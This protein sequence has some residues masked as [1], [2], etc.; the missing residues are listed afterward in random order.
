MSSPASG[1][2]HPG[3]APADGSAV[4]LVNLGT[5]ASPTTAATRRY[6]AEFL[7]D[8]RVIELPRLVWL[9]LLYG[10]ILPLRAARSAKAYRQ[11][12]LPDGSPLRVHSE[13]LAAELERT[14]RQQGIDLPVRLAMRY[15]SPSVAATLRALRAEGL[16]R[17][18]VLPLYPQY[19]ATTTASVFDAVG[20]ELRGWRRIPELRTIAD[21]HR[22]PAWLDAVA[23]SVRGH[24]RTHPRG[25]RLL[26]SFHGIPQRYVDAG[27]PYYEQCVVSAR[28]IATRLGL[29]DDAW[30]LCF[31][32]RVGREAWLQPYTEATI[33]ACAARGQ[34][35]LDVVCPGFAVDCLETLEEI[36]LQ[37]AA[38][39]I[40]AGGERLSYV[41]ALNASSAHAGALAALVRRHA[42]DWPELARGAALSSDA[43][44]R[45]PDPLVRTR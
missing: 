25:E 14:L 20:A 16:R 27:D 19:S 9:P 33:R 23:E 34:R 24:W 45:L 32:S 21:Y 35:R 44:E 11:I 1:P 36:A 2:A 42:A 30:E 40:A 29:A 10:V 38:A 28:L 26:F 5:P 41:P 12:W 43:G 37:N 39:F 31:Q 3:S 15:G 22:E 6:L 13:R 4:L 18:L 7:A 8:P 17:V